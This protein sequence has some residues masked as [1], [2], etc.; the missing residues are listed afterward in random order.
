MN[1]RLLVAMAGYR[2][3]WGAGEIR[4]VSEDEA[5]RLVQKGFAEYV[6]QAPAATIA[7]E[8]A[9][10][11]RQARAEKRPGRKPNKR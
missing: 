3:H 2:T 8:E 11:K 7:I 5:E 6:V 10:D 4:E 9:E 1:V